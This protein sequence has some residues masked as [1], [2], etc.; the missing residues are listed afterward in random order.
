[1]SDFLL[2]LRDLFIAVFFESALALLWISLIAS[3]FSSP[4]DFVRKPIT[5]QYQW[6]RRRIEWLRTNR[7]MAIAAVSILLILGYPLGVAMQRATD[8]FVELGSVWMP[9]SSE[10][11]SSPKREFDTQ[12]KSYATK[13]WAYL[14]NIPLD[15][16]GRDEEIRRKTIEDFRYKLQSEAEAVLR[17]PAG[18]AIDPEEALKVARKAHTR[19]AFANE[20]G[21]YLRE[22]FEL[23]R[24]CQATLAHVG[25]L[26]IAYFLFFVVVFS[27]QMSGRGTRRIQRCVTPAITFAVVSLLLLGGPLLHDPDEFNYPVLVLLLAVALPILV[28]PFKHKLTRKQT[29]LAALAQLAIGFS[30]ALL[31][32]YLATFAWSEHRENYFESAIVLGVEA[33]ELRHSAGL[34][35]PVVA[36]FETSASTFV[37]KKLLIADDE[38]VGSVLQCPEPLLTP[39]NCGIAKV[40]RKRKK[41]RPHTEQPR[42]A[43]VQ[44]IEGLASDRDKIVFLVGSHEG[45]DGE[46]RSDREFLIR[47]DWDDEEKELEW[48][49]SYEGLARDFQKAFQSIGEEFKL[50]DMKIHEEFNIE[51][52]AYRSVKENTGILYVGLRAPLTSDGEALILAYDLDPSRPPADFSFTT[53]RA[54]LRDREI[55]GLD[56]DSDQQ[57]LLI[58]A[59]A[60]KTEDPDLRQPG[61]LLAYSLETS[62]Y[63]LI[64]DFRNQRGIPEAVSRTPSGRLLVLFDG[65]SKADRG[66]LYLQD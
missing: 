62:S 3:A 58:V 40:Q 25:L 23:V 31:I 12:P 9:K 8:D 16:I 39:W 5:T 42:L 18:G 24:I 56:W 20:S 53:H 44:D 26:A 47:A 35:Q 22:L 64:Y 55:R 48:L 61:V 4:Q 19:R 11:K 66:G 36:G 7:S 17:T 38:L 41:S 14:K 28:F 59:V 49:W 13:L 2:G 60:N 32:W 63:K 43:A 51:G 1:M 34:A 15:P 46:R 54:D 10:F 52:L 21:T 57:R 50:T 30:I 65:N 29:D 45:K 33:A 6:L 27:A 37:G